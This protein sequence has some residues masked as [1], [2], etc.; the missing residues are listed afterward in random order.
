MMPSSL[1]WKGGLAGSI[2]AA[3]I[4]RCRI[5]SAVASYCIAE[6]QVGKVGGAD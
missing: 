4:A 3:T 6:G 1:L 5:T 2:A